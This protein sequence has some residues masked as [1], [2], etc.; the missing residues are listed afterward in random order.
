M[1]K[2]T[3][4]FYKPTDTWFKRVC[5]HINCLLVLQDALASSETVSI[6]VLYTNYQVYKITVNGISLIL[7]P[8]STANRQSVIATAIAIAKLATKSVIPVTT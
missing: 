2:V 5:E 6:Q 4:T 8:E 1:L 3:R 7:L